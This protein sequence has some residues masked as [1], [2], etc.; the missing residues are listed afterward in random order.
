MSGWFDTAWKNGHM[1]EPKHLAEEVDPMT[2]I[3][4]QLLA[5]QNKKEDE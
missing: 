1:T 3:Y 2:P 4:N 5:E